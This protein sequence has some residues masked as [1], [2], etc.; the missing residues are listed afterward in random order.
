MLTTHLIQI[1]QCI[2]H[3]GEIED[4]VKVDNVILLILCEFTQSL[5]SYDVDIGQAA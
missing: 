5:I 2:I 3:L 4:T 1:Y